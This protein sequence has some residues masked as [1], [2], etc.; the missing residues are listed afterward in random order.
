MI[1]ALLELDRV[2]EA[3]SQF[4]ALFGLEET[5]RHLDQAYLRAA[6]VLGRAS[7]RAAAIDVMQSLVA[8]NPRSASA[9]FAMAHL[10]VRGGDLDKALGSADEA[11]KR[12]P[13]WEE[14]ALF[15]ARILLSQ[16]D[17]QKASAFY[18]SFL[19]RNRGETSVRLN[20]ARF[21]IDQKEWPQAL[22]ELRRVAAE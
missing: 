2:A 14:A 9:H 12:R 13:D 1:S 4:E 18:E 8:L 21:L 20:Y 7:N 22:D 10:M 6:A 11:L 15:K 16:K 5:R 19:A 3:K 17:S